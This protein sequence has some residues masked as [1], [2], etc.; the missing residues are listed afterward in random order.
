M[1]EIKKIIIIIIDIYLFGTDTKL[2]QNKGSDNMTPQQIEYVLAVAE[3]RSFSKAA[4][5]LFVTQPS[6]SKF[7][8]NLENSLGVILFDRSNSPITITEAGQIFIDTANK[9]KDLEDDMTMKMSELIGMKNGTLKIGTS[10]FYSA[11]MLMKTILNFHKKY[12]DIQISIYED[13]YGNL[14]ELISRGE[15]DIMIGNSVVDNELY[16]VEE[17]CMEKLYLAVPAQKSI[18][19]EISEYALSAEDIKLNSEKLFISDNV[20]LEMFKDEKFIFYNNTDSRYQTVKRICRSAGFTPFIAFKSNNLETIFSFVRSGL[21]V[22]FIP[23][24]Y[25]KFADVSDHPVYYAI[26]NPELEGN[27]K[28]IYKKNKYLSRAAVE[29]CNMLKS[30][31]GM[32]TWK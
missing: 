18:N 16:N 27:I 32:G 23:D 26:N 17:L 2:D 22:A 30:L 19:N 1:T 25:V 5:R 7:I 28:L 10:T 3:E 9:M 20:E 14:E 15:L 21:G 31:I 24:T 4:K 11:N 13:S 8:I 29:F 6:L 12:P